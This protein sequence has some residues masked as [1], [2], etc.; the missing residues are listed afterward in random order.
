MFIS[1]LDDLMAVLD[2][3]LRTLDRFVGKADQEALK[4]IAAR[5]DALVGQVVAHLDRPKEMGDVV[6][7]LRSL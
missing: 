1:A 2:A 3:S 6:L 5:K 7:R 4:A